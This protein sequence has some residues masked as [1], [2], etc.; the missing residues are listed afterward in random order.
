MLGWGGLTLGHRTGTS[1]LPCGSVRV[2]V[3]GAPTARFP[4]HEEVVDHGAGGVE[5]GGQHTRGGTLVWKEQNTDLG[6]QVRNN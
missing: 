2:W 5:L 4:T 6:K 1:L 3:P